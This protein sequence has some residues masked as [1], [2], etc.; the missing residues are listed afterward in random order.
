[1]AIVFAA[2]VVLIVGIA[3]TINSS[4]S[5]DDSGPNSTSQVEGTGSE[6]EIT[7]DLCGALDQPL[8]SLLESIY[9]GT[10]TEESWDSFGFDISR[11]E[12]PASQL[13]SSSDMKSG[14]E[15]LQAW[16]ALPAQTAMDSFEDSGIEPLAI[17]CIE[18]GS[19]MSAVQAV[20]SELGQGTLND[21][22]RR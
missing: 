16:V 21:V 20:L 17:G 15:M 22:S 14:F 6:Q 5:R 7:S 10:V 11:G 12:N 13:S 9:S 3:N 4:S 19:D 1:V 8:A 18:N 2:I